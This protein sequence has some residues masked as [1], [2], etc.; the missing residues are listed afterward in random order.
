MFRVNFAN[1]F[2]ETVASVA[3]KTFHDSTITQ[4]SFTYSKST[5]ERRPGCFI[6]NFEQISNIVPLFQC[7]H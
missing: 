7:F 3:R 2:T 5:V 4:L 1:F 6:V